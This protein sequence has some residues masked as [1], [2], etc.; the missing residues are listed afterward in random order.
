LNVDAVKL[1]Q[2]QDPAARFDGARELIEALEKFLGPEVTS[3]PDEWILKYL[4]DEVLLE[5]AHSVA[6]LKF[7]QPAPPYA[8]WGMVGMGILAGLSL[9]GATYSWGHRAGQFYQIEQQK[10]VEQ[11]ELKAKAREK[12][13]HR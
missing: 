2:E 13:S 7:T 12:R 1:V 4:D 9:L 10:A 5:P 3:R 8:F 6:N 11:L